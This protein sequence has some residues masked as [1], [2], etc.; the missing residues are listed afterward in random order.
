MFGMG[1]KVSQM[2]MKQALKSLTPSENRMFVSLADII[3]GIEY[4]QA[5]ALADCIDT[6]DMDLEVHH[7]REQRREELLTV[8]DSVADQE[9]RHYWFAQVVEL[10]SP[11]RAAEYVGYGPYEWRE[12][13]ETW[14]EQYR[15]M[16]VVDKPLHD[17]ERA[18]IGHVAAM[19]VE[20]SFGITLDEFVAGVINWDRGAALETV[21]AGPIRSYTTTI[22]QLAEEIEQRDRRI[23]ELEARVEDLE[24]DT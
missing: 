13:L 8:A 19:H 22:H 14:Y 3:S 11:E 7:D 12:Q 10:D 20:E 24:T 16:G 21:I 18:D 6:A 9:F 1:G 23:E 15:K 5:D 17:A 2:G 4:E